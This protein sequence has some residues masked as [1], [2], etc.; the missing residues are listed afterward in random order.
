MS[1]RS[2]VHTPGGAR[3]RI[4]PCSFDARSLLDTWVPTSEE[5][6]GIP[7]KS[8]KPP[9]HPTDP[10]RRSSRKG[11]ARPIAITG[12]QSKAP[13]AG[14][15]RQ[16]DITCRKALFRV[17]SKSVTVET[18]QWSMR[19][20]MMPRVGDHLRHSSGVQ[21]GRRQ[22]KE[23]R[24]A[25]GMSPLPAGSAPPASAGN[26][27][28]ARITPGRLRERKSTE[29]RERPTVHMGIHSRVEKMLHREDAM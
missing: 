29:S 18:C 1:S 4:F 12:S 3:N 26:P 2:R 16:P 17:R 28:T 15:L 9:R 8:G 6:H 25:S 20:R 21:A 22:R 5:L 11:L 7:T 19:R 27:T 14:L 23:R 24:R 10:R 13:P